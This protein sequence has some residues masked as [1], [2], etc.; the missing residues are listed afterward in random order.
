MG[1]YGAIR[2]E[3]AMSDLSICGLRWRARTGSNFQ[4][5]DKELLG[6]IREPDLNRI[7]CQLENFDLDNVAIPI[8][9]QRTPGQVHQPDVGHAPSAIFLK[10]VHEVGPAFVPGN[11]LGDNQGRYR[12][13]RLWP[14]SGEHRHI[15]NPVG[16]L[17]HLQTL[18]N[19]RE[20][21]VRLA[22]W[23]KASEQVASRLSMFENRHRPLNQLSA[24]V[25]AV[26]VGETRGEILG[27]GKLRS[28]GH[29]QKLIASGSGYNK[30]M[31]RREILSLATSASLVGVSRLRAV[32]APAAPVSIAKCPSY[33]ED[34][35]QVMSTMFDQ[36]GGLGRV[37][38]NKTVTIKLNLTG[39]P[40]LRFQG[41]PLG[42]THYTHPKTLMAMVHL[43]DQ[44]GATRIR[45][46]ES[47]WAT[48]GRSKSTC[49]IPAGMCARCS[50]VSHE[51]RIREHERARARANATRV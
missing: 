18:F 32:P 35:A 30:F 44:A 14:R 15:G 38:K 43:L 3:L 16:I 8:K 40:A 13:Y 49:S 12:G 41:L 1:P 23:A 34:V 6:Q 24:Y 39:S 36:L 20:K 17:H 50:G 28:R 22:Q 19:R 42:S 27:R 37:V 5:D 11:D 31:T 4:P 48:A 25:V 10:F 21:R 45:L 7:A 26:E 29:I 46:V 9:Q 47:A 2:W 51:A 33:D